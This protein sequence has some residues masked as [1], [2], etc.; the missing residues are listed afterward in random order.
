MGWKQKLFIPIIWCFLQRISNTQFALQ[1]P[2]I[3]PNTNEIP[4]LEFQGDGYAS[5]ET[6]ALYNG[7]VKEDQISF[8]ICHRHRLITIQIEH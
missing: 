5:A 6:W 2:E 3:N 7:T 8:T 4:V 1:Q